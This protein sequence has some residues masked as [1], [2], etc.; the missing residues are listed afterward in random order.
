M[1]KPVPKPPTCPFCGRFIK[2]PELLPI[3]LSDLEAGVCECGSVYVC[4]VTGHNRG[5][6]FIEALFLATAGDWDLMWELIPEEDYKEVWIENYDLK[7]HTILPMP[8]TSRIVS[9]GALCFLKVADDIRELKHVKLSQALQKEPLSEKDFNKPKRKLSKRELE[10]L[11]E[12]EDFNTLNIY[13]VSEPL[14]LNVLQ[15]FFYHPDPVFRRKAV[16]AL[17]KVSPA[18]AKVYPE[19]LLDFIKRLLYA[20]ADSAS[21]AW[22]ALEAVGEIIRETGDRYA[23]FIKNLLAFLKFPEYHVYVLYA[24][25]RISEKNPEVLK[26]HSYFLLLDLI[27]RSSSEIKALILKTFVNLGAKEISPYLDKLN[28]EEET[29]VFNHETFSYEKV[30][31]KEIIQQIQ[32]G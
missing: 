13:I 6:A 24:L 15:K 5:N 1:K 27:E 21:S 3:G 32:R 19:R 31:L 8:A 28:P 30:K 26:K 29:E 20:A 22:G 2:K 25:Y 23:I 9:K 18:L 12:K 11:I 17:G 16:V 7:T 4:D 10:E 14:N